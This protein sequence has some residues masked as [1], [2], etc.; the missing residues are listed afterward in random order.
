MRVELDIA[1]TQLRQRPRA[2]SV[3]IVGIA[4][5]VA[6]FLAVSAL[7]RGSEQDFLARLV[8]ESPH[9]TVSDQFRK[10]RVQPA[11]LR[12]PDA[13]VAV[14]NVRPQV[15]T[16]GIRSY[17]SKLDAIAALPGVRVAP[18]L[19][20]A[21]VLTFAG[22]QQGVSLSG[23]VPASMQTVST[24]E[25]N[26]AEGTLDDLAAS[27]NGIVIGRGLADKFGLARGDTVTVVAAG[28][29]AR[30]MKVVGIF[31]TGNAAFDEG[32][33]FVQLKRAQTLL[34][35]PNRVNRFLIQLD[36]PHA[37]R[38]LAA[39][40]E[41]DFGYKAVSWMEATEDLL[42][43]LTVRNVIMYSVVLAI[44]LV[45]AFGIYNTVSTMVIDK[46]RDTA[47][48]K[49]MGFQARD[50]RTI[51]LL[52]GVIMGLLGSAAGLLLG[53]GLM[54][55]LAG[56]ELKPPGASDIV[57]M[58]IWWGGEQYLIAFGF[59]MLACLGAAFF[60]ARKAGRLRPVDTLRGAA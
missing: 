58:P 53:H 48:L 19:H 17:R 4:L 52:Q 9:V 15:E 36:D 55:V 33:T 11:Q 43:L 46:R 1:L 56:I 16:R 54:R 25:D 39:Q 31:R 21:A 47:I 40:L 10:A 35:R 20:G 3:S 32:E 7:M 2:T 49:A 26:M 27:P 57:N 45:A 60:P 50:V 30:V 42:S 18:V 51:F 5:G 8:D 38:T 22:Q 44:L 13:T 34:A 28:S 24:I 23:I 6:F 12:W 37:A 14:S 29:G 41:S 59:A